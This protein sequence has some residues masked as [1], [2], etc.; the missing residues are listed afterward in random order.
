[1]PRWRGPLKTG[2]ERHAGRDGA[3]RGTERSRPCAEIDWRRSGQT[4]LST[5]E[6]LEAPHDEASAFRQWYLAGSWCY[7]WSMESV[8][9]YRLL[10]SRA[11]RGD[12][13]RHKEG[14]FLLKRPRKHPTIGPPAMEI[15]YVTVH[16][17]YNVDPFATEWLIAPVKKREGNPYPDRFSIGRAPNCDIVLRVHFISKVH[18]HILRESDGSFSLRDNQA[19]NSTFHNGRSLESGSKCPLALGDEVSFGA[20]DFEFVDAGQLYG[21]L[22]SIEGE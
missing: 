15:S 10:A 17:K 13:I 12:F 9:K 3:R 6:L 5:T 14:L 22:R 7:G 1:M 2:T 20:M 11:T 8:D 19:S 21:I 18:A 16:A 4:C